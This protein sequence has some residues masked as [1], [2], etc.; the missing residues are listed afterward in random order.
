MI[1]INRR[2]RDLGVSRLDPGTTRT[3]RLHKAE[4]R[5]WEIRNRAQ[6]GSTA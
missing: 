5:A 3:T 1:R 6:Q 4:L 2:H